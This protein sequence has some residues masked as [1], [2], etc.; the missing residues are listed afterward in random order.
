MQQSYV[1]NGQYNQYQ[2]QQSLGMPPAPPASPQ[3]FNSQLNSVQIPN[4]PGAQQPVIIT[5][6]GGKK[7]KKT[8]QTILNAIIAILAAVLI[9]GIIVLAVKQGKEMVKEANQQQASTDTGQSNGTELQ[10][11]IADKQPILRKSDPVIIKELKD[12]NNNPA[13]T[14]LESINQS[15]SQ[16]L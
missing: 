11:G 15:Q 12:V 3:Q 6:G 13:G 16:Q 2:Q 14:N 7:K 5:Q 1:E 10:S 4:Q 8:G 9:V